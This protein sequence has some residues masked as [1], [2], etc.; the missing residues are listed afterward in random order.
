[1][2]GNDGKAST[3]YTAPPPPPALAGGSGAVVSVQAT[4]IGTDAVTSPSHGT[5]SVDIRLVPPGVI[6]PPASTPTPKFTYTPTPVNFNIPVIFDGSA[7]C[8]GSADA[9]GNCLPS[10]SAIAS[11]RWD[12][13]DGGTGSGRTATH[14]YVAS[15]TPATSF[16]V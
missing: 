1:I 7:S 3:I 10:S 4:P 14:T 5:P 13:G 11:Y 8:P 15:T 16:T 2:T 6:L 9:N 12:F